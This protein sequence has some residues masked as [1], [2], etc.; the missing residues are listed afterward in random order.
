MY[1]EEPEEFGRPA[2]AR[3]ELPPKPSMAPSW[4]LLGFVIGAVFVWMLP[5][6]PAPSA[7][8]LSEAPPPVAVA[9]TPPQ[10][11]VIEAVFAEWGS[12][13]AWEND[14]TEVA[15]WSGETKSYSVCFQVLR[16]GGM[17]FF[18][19]IPRLT[20]P[21]LS[22]G[23]PDNSPLQLTESEAQRAEWIG[24]KNQETW[25]AISEAARNQASPLPPST[26]AR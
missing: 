16:T 1:P 15:L 8:S 26:G 10:I 25:R 13:A 21:V 12:A 9:K 18:R 20:R 2:P 5:R 4:V 11:A 22:R 7:L 6:S 23:V 17:Y 19:S 24:A 3:P 14:L